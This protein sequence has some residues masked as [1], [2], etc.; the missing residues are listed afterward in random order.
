MSEINGGKLD[1]EEVILT[2]KN[3]V[4]PTQELLLEL[5]RV[6]V[7]TSPNSAYLLMRACLERCI[8]SFFD[9]IGKPFGSARF[10]QLQDALDRLETHLNDANEKSVLQLVKVLKNEATTKEHFMKTKISLD[11]INHNHRL[12]ATPDNVREMWLRVSQI[13]TYLAKYDIAQ[14]S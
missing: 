10:V 4:P 11:A 1:I 14:N 7:K 3:F 5:S 12:A 8:K 9:K 6:Y 13:L 2:S